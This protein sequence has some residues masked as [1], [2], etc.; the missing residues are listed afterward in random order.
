ME[1]GAKP[2]GPIR[3]Y[4]WENAA[5]KA[6]GNEPSASRL[7]YPAV[8][9]QLS[10]WLVAR[11]FMKITSLI[12][13]LFIALCLIGCSG[14]DEASGNAKRLVPTKAAE[15]T[16]SPDYKFERTTKSGIQCYVRP[17]TPEIVEAIPAN[18]PDREF[19]MTG[20]QPHFLVPIRDNKIVKLNKEE[21]AEVAAFTIEKMIESDPELKKV[22]KDGG[23][24]Q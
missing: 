11:R 5:E 23:R 7:V 13:L 24:K 15:V 17:L 20:A 10:S 8:K 12:G 4:A 18:S 14:G 16:G 6:V 21:S 1:M 2:V 22:V 19:L 3:R 9:T